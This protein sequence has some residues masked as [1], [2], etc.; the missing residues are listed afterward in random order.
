[1]IISSRR[2]DF[3]KA[4]KQ[5]YDST[6]LPVHYVRVA[7]I[8]GISKWSAYEM[9]KSLEIDGLLSSQYEVN[10][11]EKHPGRAQILFI[12]TQLLFQVLNA[13]AL[14]VK[15][16]SREWLQVRDRLLSVF[17]GLDRRTASALLE[18]LSSELAAIDNPLVFCAYAATL[19]IAQVQSLSGTALALI[20]TIIRGAVKAETGL[21]LFAGALMGILF[22]IAAPAQKMTQ[23]NSYVAGFQKNLEALN[24][25]EQSVLLDFVDKALRKAA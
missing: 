24:P 2:L 19:L 25:T 22:K 10:S 17:D 18:Q 9:L 23:L 8:L 20:R 1:M 16:T 5:I 15:A 11:G 13:T 4:I 12:P 3:L 7:E 14:E 21:T 6:S